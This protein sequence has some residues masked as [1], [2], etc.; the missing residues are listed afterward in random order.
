MLPSETIMVYCKI[1]R[2]TQ[3]RCR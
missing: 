3:I 2:N 1:I